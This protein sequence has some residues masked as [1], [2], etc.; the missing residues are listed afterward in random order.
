MAAVPLLHTIVASSIA[1]PSS[2]KFILKP[3]YEE[4]ESL[5]NDYM[6]DQDSGQ[7]FEKRDQISTFEG[8]I[9]S[10]ND[11]GVIFDVLHEIA[12]SDEQID[13]LANTITTLVQN[14]S[15]MVDGVNITLNY[16]NIW[17]SIKKSGLVESLLNGLLLDPENRLYVAR[18]SGG[19]LRRDIWISKIIYDLGNGQ[20]LTVKY[21]ADTIRNFKS[22]APELTKSNST[23]PLVYKRDDDKYSGSAQQFFNNLIGAVINSELVGGS[24][25][26]FLIALNR[27]GVALSV[28]LKVLGDGQTLSMSRKL[29]SKLYDNGLFDNIDLDKYYS[30]L[31]K[32]NKLSNAVQVVLTNPTYSPGVAKILQQME[33]DGVFYV[34]QH[35]LHGF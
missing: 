13:N 26:N 14:G 31:K 33:N 8:I 29:V 10:V 15:T 34:V 21:L 23:D 35:G 2:K 4:I 11:S 18:A 1:H 9:Q 12:G 22:K 24:L 7:I 17:N 28:T 16:T 19:L 32:G 3:E 20:K 25:E 27:T 6:G 5:V 30:D